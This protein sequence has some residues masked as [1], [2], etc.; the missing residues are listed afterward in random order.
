MSIH[1]QNE[2]PVN[3]S[4]GAGNGL[5]AFRDNAQRAIEAGY[6]PI[7][8]FLV[9][10]KGLD[11][12]RAKAPSIKKW[13]QFRLRQMEPAE[14][15]KINA[16][17][18]N[19]QI[20][21]AVGKVPSMYGN[22]WLLVLDF[23]TDDVAFLET[24]KANLPPFVVARRGKKG[25]CVPFVIEIPEGEDVHEYL[26]KNGIDAAYC[27]PNDDGTGPGRRILE[28]PRN[29]RIP[30]SIHPETKKPYVWTSDASIYDTIPDELSEVTIDTL[31]KLVSAL[32]PWFYKKPVHQET[33]KRDVV[34]TGELSANERTSYQRMAD[35]AYDKHVPAL[36]NMKGKG[37]RGDALYRAA[38]ALAVW[39]KYGFLD[40]S[41]IAKDLFDACATNGFLNAD[42]ADEVNKTIT[43]ALDKN[44]LLPE[45]RNAKLKP[46]TIAKA[47]SAVK[48][49]RGP[50]VDAAQMAHDELGDPAEAGTPA[51]DGTEL[52]DDEPQEAA[53]ELCEA[54]DDAVQ[55]TEKLL[56]DITD[57]RELVE[58]LAALEEIEWLPRADE[59]RTVH[60]LTKA[61]L[62]KLVKRRR[63]ELSQTQAKQACG[64]YPV[65]HRDT[66]RA[67]AAF[68]RAKFYPHLIHIQDEFLNWQ[69]GAYV[70]IDEAYLI[71][72]IA[73]FL[74]SAKTEVPN[75]VT[76]LVGLS[77]FKPRSED[78]HQVLTALMHICGVDSEV[79]HAPSWINPCEVDA[80]Q[81]ISFPNGWLDTVGGGFY[82]PT[83]NLFTRNSLGFDYDPEASEPVKFFEFLDQVWPSVEEREEYI[84]QLQRMMGLLLVP[85]TS[86]EKIFL[87]LGVGGSGKG[88]L[89]KLIEKLVGIANYATAKGRSLVKNDHVL[90]SLRGKT[91]ITI[92]DMTVPKDIAEDLAELLKSISGQDTQPLNRKNKSVLFEKLPG[93]ILIGANAIPD[94]PDP[95][96]GLSRRYVPFRF[97]HT[98]RDNPDSKLG[99]KLAAELPGILLWCLEGL[100]CVQ[101]SPDTAFKLGPLAKSELDGIDDIGNPLLRFV[102]ARLTIGSDMTAPKD[103]VYAAYK[104]WHIL[105]NDE[106]KA[107]SKAWFGRRLMGAVPSITTAQI[108][109]KGFQVESY[110]GIE[111]N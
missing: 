85:D 3:S 100:R 19:A 29:F 36:R 18:P 30:P 10:P 26:K 103:A 106:S 67:S 75:P 6:S 63:L 95:G 49:M 69:S 38:C 5:Q 23:D 9:A 97:K 71:S 4:C 43:L 47:S 77:R 25:C 59:L 99:G 84:P 102:Q 66:P 28:F 87:F 7:P 53:V 111:L 48:V 11:P 70:N 82:A 20:S 107:L 33:P 83:P 89:T 86:L 41:A 90:A 40:R 15:T 109:P 13:E 37:G 56:E 92:P 22:F 105:D 45:L 16:D 31:K 88:T 80:T 60:K 98:F 50:V 57:L 58:R 72:R 52:P 35:K 1:T 21:L 64:S 62:K 2:S 78:V 93:R 76:G 94:M 79:V 17:Q 61:E 74:D 51:P 54:L 108:G 27:A 110:R 101:E 39:C 73:E 65:M 91:L 34:S 68:F 42:G 14:I 55:P 81:I 104:T 24:A 12:K 96:F 44:D 46:K 32:S 8:S